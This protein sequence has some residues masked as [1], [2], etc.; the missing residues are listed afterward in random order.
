MESLPTEFT[1]G[2]FL[3]ELIARTHK[4]PHRKD[5]AIYRR[6]RVGEGYKPHF[7]VVIVRKQQ[8]G[9]M[10]MAGQVIQ[11][12]AKELYPPV[13]R[14]GTDGWTFHHYDKAMLW[15]SKITGKATIQTRKIS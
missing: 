12:K 8:D 9:E 13:T 15:F 14:W 5:V 1:K 7:E 11:M 3:Q 10:K 6:T 2:N 4:G